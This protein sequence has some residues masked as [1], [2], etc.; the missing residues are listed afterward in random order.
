MLHCRNMST[1]PHLSIKTNW[2]VTTCSQCEHTKK[3]H[4]WANPHILFFHAC[5]A[6]H[7][8]KRSFVQSRSWLHSQTNSLPQIPDSRPHLFLPHILFF[9]AYTTENLIKAIVAYDS[10]TNSLPQVPGSRPDPITS[11]VQLL[12]CTISQKEQWPMIHLSPS[13]ASWISIKIL[14]SMS[15]I[16][17]QQ[18]PMA[19]ETKNHTVTQHRPRKAWFLSKFIVCWGS[20]LNK[21]YIPHSTP[22]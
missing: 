16:S 4:K 21:D 8:I 3:L 7:F 18:V 12:L 6:E 15:E 5:A 14:S 19:I 13:M 9:H 17:A 11:D 20:N 22:A 1:P 10:K 2:I